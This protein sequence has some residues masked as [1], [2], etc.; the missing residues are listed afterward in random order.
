M[1]TLAAVVRE[2][3]KLVIETVELAPPKANEVLVRVYAAGVCHSDLH[4]LRGELRATPPLVLGHEGA[5]IVEQVGS[6]V[7]HVKPGERVLVNWLPADGTC[8]ICLKGFPNLC[9]RF[10]KTLYQGFLS[11]G[12][13]RFCSSDGMPIKH[14]LSASTMSEY[15]VI[16]QASAIPFPSDVPFDVAAIIGCAV[17]TGV[18]AVVNTANVKPGSSAAVIGCGG[19]GLSIVMGLKLAGCYP[20]IAVDVMDNKLNWAK[21][22][23]ATETINPLQANVV[24][25]CK[26]FVH[27]GPDYVFDSV[28]SATTI[29]QALQ[30]V[31]PG[32]TAVIAGMHSAKINVS[33]PAGNLIFQNKRL[34]GSFYGSMRPQVDL[35]HLIDLYRAGRLPVSGLITR[36]YK[37]QDVIQAF[38]DME[39][40]E[41]ARGVISFQ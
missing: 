20:I 17:A 12:T 15:I 34:L 10:P 24:E 27:N 37:L 9:E 40:G 31:A 5:G 38:A 2:T 28:G 8:P 35:P 39:A 14:Y 16:D 26:A 32:G 21:S 18:G 41:V 30:A 7:T 13:S 6:A 25:T 29:P 11:D 3:N 1:K 19:V 22:F 33:I 4:T 36:R 23:G